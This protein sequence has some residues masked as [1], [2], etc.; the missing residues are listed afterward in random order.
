VA[1]SGD[2]FKFRE[3]GQFILHDFARSTNAFPT[4][5]PD[6]NKLS[7][8]LKR[9]RT[10]LAHSLANLLITDTVTQTNV[11]ID[12]RT[13][14]DQS[15]NENGYDFNSIAFCRDKVMLHKKKRTCVYSGAL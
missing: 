13:I 11:H 1:L 4:L 5:R 8:L 7:E 14:S 6:R 3:L 15:V 12:S 10:E 9:L 2:F